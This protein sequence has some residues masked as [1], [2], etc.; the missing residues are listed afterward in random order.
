MQ[1]EDNYKLIFKHQGH[2]G[3]I[4]DFEWNKESPW[5]MVATS[6]D[7]EVTIGKVKM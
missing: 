6:D 2:K 1:N 5:T 3:P 7:A 4:V